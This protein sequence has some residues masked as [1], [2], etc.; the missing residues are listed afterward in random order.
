MAGLQPGQAG[1][2]FTLALLTWESHPPPPFQSV[3]SEK[4]LLGGLTTP[5]THV[6][7][8]DAFISIVNGEGRALA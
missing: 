1:V 3:S 4:T 2:A 8:C 5:V 7:L 6:A